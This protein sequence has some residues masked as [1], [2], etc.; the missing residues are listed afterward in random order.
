VRKPAAQDRR[1]GSESGGMAQDLLDVMIAMREQRRAYAV[2]TVVETTGSSSAK[3][4]SK[5]VIDERGRVVA[6]WV[7]GGCAES[8]T[9]S[10]A[11]SCMESG[12][13][14]V[15]D[16]DLTSEVLGAG[17]PCGGSMRVY[18]E[19]AFPR[20]ALWV[21]GHGRVAESLCLMGDLQGFDVV[22]IDPLADREHYPVAMRLVTD[23]PLYEQLE[24]RKGDFVVIATQHKGD[25]RSLMRALRSEAGYLA[26][27]ASVRRAR[28][29][30]DYL[31][32]EGYSER[33]LERV[34][35]PAGL[36]LGARTPEEIAL[37]VLGEIVMVRRNGN[38]GLMRDRL[39]GGG[40][41]HPLPVVEPVTGAACA[42]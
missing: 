25:H 4:G 15:L 28:L 35:A 42:G 3:T 12:E 13:T 29:V 8:M 6:G 41:E 21:M 26:L 30:L 23:D 7:G 20:P 11:L 34:R 31:R 24:P 36:D 1:T 2:A 16:I 33:D 5:A 9:C 32:R 10:Q 22:V 38:G 27:I 19:P 14:A 40:G 39:K 18:V 17:M 37:C